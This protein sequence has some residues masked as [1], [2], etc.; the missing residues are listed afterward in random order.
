[1][2]RERPPL[3][4]PHGEGQR[5]DGLTRSSL[6]VSLASSIF[7]PLSVIVAARPVRLEIISADS[8]KLAPHQR[9]RSCSQGRICRLGWNRFIPQILSL[10]LLRPS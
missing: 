2:I 6:S 10:S 3:V 9:Q 5:K 7:D 8:T 1:V 4:L